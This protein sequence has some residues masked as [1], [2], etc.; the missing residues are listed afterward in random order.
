MRAQDEVA[1]QFGANLVRLRKRAGISQEELGFRSDLH[2]TEVGMLERGIRL[3]RIDTLLKVAGA[4][5]LEPGDL[6]DGLSWTPGLPRTGSFQ[7]GGAEEG[8]ES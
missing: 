1:R 8:S 5:G 4:L 7:A 3:P 6:L 2:R